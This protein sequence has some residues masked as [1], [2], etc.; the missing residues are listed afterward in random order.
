MQTCKVVQEDAN[1]DLRLTGLVLTMYRTGTTLAKR[2]EETVEKMPA[3]YLWK[4]R[5]NVEVAESPA[6]KQPI[7]VYAPHSIGAED[8]TKMVDDVL[9][10]NK[11]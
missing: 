1:A 4:I 9:A 8:Y 5:Q 3:L 2:V 7:Q 11:K 10:N 6:K